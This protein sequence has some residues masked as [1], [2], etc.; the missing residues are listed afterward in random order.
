VK[1][2]VLPV[3][4]LTLFALPAAAQHFGI[5]GGVNLNRDSVSLGLPIGSGPSDE[6]TL[7]GGVAVDAEV[8]DQLRFQME[9]LYQRRSTTITFLDSTGLPPIETEYRLDYF[10]VP[11]LL[12][13]DLSP[14]P[15][16]PYAVAG[17]QLGFRFRAHAE[18]RSAG[19]TRDDDVGDQFKRTDVAL[20][21][22]GG[23]AYRIRGGVFLTGDL[24]YVHGLTNISENPTGADEWKTRSLQIM[25]GVAFRF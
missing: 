21:V 23:V 13:Y 10:V 4:A 19:N 24:R 6:T 7:V 9:V 20:V 25:G 5:K 11:L 22:G 18:S 8:W 14:G 3:L 1:P 2:R 12:R 15:F 16:I 17:T